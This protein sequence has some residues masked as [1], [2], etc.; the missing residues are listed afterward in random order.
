VY[1][2]LLVREVGGASVQRDI[3]ESS[4]VTGLAGSARV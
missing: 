4:S 3:D 1:S 2:G